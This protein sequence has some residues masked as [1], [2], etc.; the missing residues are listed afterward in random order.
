M[1][2]AAGLG[3]IGLGH[4]RERIRNGPNIVFP[5]AVGAAVNIGTAL[6]EQF[7][8]RSLLVHL[9]FFMTVTA[10]DFCETRAV[11]SRRIRMT[12]SAAFLAVNG[13]GKCFFID[14]ELLDRA[15]GPRH[16][17]IHVTVAE[18]ALRI[19]RC[20]AQLRKEEQR[21][22]NRRYFK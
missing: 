18:K 19:I 14:V 3:L 8:M 11:I 9:A 2:F 13:S 10:L 15:V 12:G 17:E 22:D 6:F 5:V 4:V 16:L 1:A 20:I 21:E 7:S